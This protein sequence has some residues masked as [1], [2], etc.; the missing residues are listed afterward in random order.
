MWVA[1]SRNKCSR[2]W[3]DSTRINQHDLSRMR[4]GAENDSI[5][6]FGAIRQLSRFLFDRGNSVHEVCIVSLYGLPENRY[7]DTYHLVKHVY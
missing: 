5:R 7:L 4:Q 3:P 1:L 6:P 2:T